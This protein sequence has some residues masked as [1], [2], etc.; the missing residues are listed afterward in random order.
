VKFKEAQQLEEIEMKLQIQ[1][2][3]EEETEETD[4]ENQ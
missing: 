4:E 2:E 3:N 1:E